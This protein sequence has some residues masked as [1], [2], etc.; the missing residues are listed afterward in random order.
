MRPID[1]AP[2]IIPTVKSGT[3]IR[4]LLAGIKTPPTLAPL[5]L[6]DDLSISRFPKRLATELRSSITSPA[7]SVIGPSIDGVVNVL[8]GSLISI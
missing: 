8:P 5:G 6:F 4:S 7:V 2:T 3:N 1:T